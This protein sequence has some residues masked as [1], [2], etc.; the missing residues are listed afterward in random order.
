MV[1]LYER[2]DSYIAGLDINVYSGRTIYI[3]LKYDNS[4]LFHSKNCREGMKG[5]LVCKLTN[6]VKS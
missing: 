6:G 2:V 1:S 4:G 5:F 3:W